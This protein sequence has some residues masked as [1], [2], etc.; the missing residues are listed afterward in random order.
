MIR[1]SS[2]CVLFAFMFIAVGCSGATDDTP[3]LGTVSGTVKLDGNPVP[4]ATVTFSPEEGGRPSSGPTDDQGFYELQYSLN[5]PGA[6]PGKHQ[7]R[8]STATTVTNEAG[9]DVEVPESIPAKYNT[10]TELVEEVKPTSQT[11]DF[12]LTSN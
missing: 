6:V 11:I 3:E 8:I 5:N 9:E 7:V 2:A 12:D 4:Q 1:N 10:K